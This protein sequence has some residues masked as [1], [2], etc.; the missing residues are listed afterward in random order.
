MKRNNLSTLSVSSRAMWVLYLITFTTFWCCNQSHQKL[1]LDRCCPR[2]FCEAGKIQNFLQLDWSFCT[3]WRNQNPHLL[4]LL[5]RTTA[6]AGDLPQMFSQNS[7]VTSHMLPT[8]RVISSAALLTGPLLRPRS[9]TTENPLA[10]L[11]DKDSTVSTKVRFMSCINLEYNGCD[12]NSK[13]FLA[14]V[15]WSHTIIHHPSRSQVRFND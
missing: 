15:V 3:L 5:S 13:K 9:K 1:W 8:A 6:L 11:V 7:S 4:F 14:K 12:S 10:V 2:D